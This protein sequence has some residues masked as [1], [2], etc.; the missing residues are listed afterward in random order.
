MGNNMSLVDL[1]C[2]ININCIGIYPYC[3]NRMY[4][5][6][7]NVE[8]LLL[9]NMTF[10]VN[11]MFNVEYTWWISFYEIAVGIVFFENVG[12]SEIIQTSEYRGN[13]FFSKKRK[14]K[15]N[16]IDKRKSSGEAWFDCSL[17][18]QGLKASY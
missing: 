3:V 6:L 9:V 5:A 10:L 1:S 16:K 15:K 18:R 12:R 4:F 14:W 7:T 11:V 17:C 2:S 13:R 8:C